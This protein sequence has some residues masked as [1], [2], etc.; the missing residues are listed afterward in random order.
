MALAVNVAAAHADTANLLTR[1]PLRFEANDGQTDP[2]VKFLA[3]GSAYTL[4]L[5]ADDMVLA[6]KADAIRLSFRGANRQARLV[7][8]DK[9]AGETNV[10]V[11]SDPSKWRSRIAGYAKIRYEE[12]YPGIDL[13]FYGNDRQLE[14]DLIVKPGADPRRIRM[15]VDGTRELSGD[16]NGDLV[17]RT[18]EGEIRFRRPFVYQAAGDQPARTIEGRYRVKGRSVSFD[19]GNYDKSKP[20][21]IDPIVV[22]QTYLGGNGDDNPGFGLGII[23]VDPYGASYVTGFTDSSTFPAT[24]G[25]YR[26]VPFTGHSPT[27][28]GRE[29][30][31][32]PGPFGPGHGS[33]VFVAKIAPDGSSLVYA[34]Y[35]GGTHSIFDHICGA[36]LDYVSGIAVDTSGQAYITGTSLSND[37]PETTAT[38]LPNGVD[39][40]PGNRMF[41]TK[42]NG[43]G[44]GLVFSARFGFMDSAGIAVGSDRSVYLTG[45]TDSGLPVTPGAFQQ[46]CGGIPLYGCIPSVTHNEWHDAFALKLNPT[47]TALVY[48]TYLGGQGLDLGRSIAVGADGQAYVT[49]LTRA[50]DFPTTPGAMPPHEPSGNLVNNLFVTKVNADGTDLIFS[51]YLGG[52]ESEQPGSV[53][54]D[55]AG[56]AYVTGST[57]SPDFPTT[58]GVLQETRPPTLGQSLFPFVTKFAPDGSLVYS[59]YLDYDGNGFGIAVD[60]E[61]RAWV[62]GASE[63]P[64]IHEVNPVQPPRCTNCQQAFIAAL[65]PT[66]SAF[67][68][69]SYIGGG[70]ALSLALNPDGDAF[71]VGPT[72]ANLPTVNPMQPNHAGGSELFLAKVA[73][74][75]VPVVTWSVPAP[76]A[77]GAPL[78]PAELDATA[79]IAGTFTYDPPAG[80]VLHAGNG[81]TLSVTFTPADSRWETVERSVLVDVGTAPLT[82]S[83]D[84]ANKFFGAPLPAVTASF[85]GFVNG[86]GPGNL[87]GTVTFSTSATSTSPVGPYPVMPGGVSSSDYAITFAP[88][89]LTILPA[90]T[91][92]AMA[93]V[94]SSAGFLQP[95]VVIAGVGALPPGA[96]SPDGTVQFL[97]GPTVVG[98]AVVTGGTAAV[99]LNGLASGVHSLTAVYSGSGNFTGSTSSGVSVTIRSAAA[100][101]FTL[102]ALANNPSALG[103]PAIISAIVVGLGGG[104]PTG[105]VQF[106]D[107][108]TP[109]ATIPL[110]NGI[111]TLSTASL[112]AGLHFVSARYLGNASFAASAASGSLLTVYTGLRPQS[113]SVTVEGTPSPSV[114]GQPVTFTATVRPVGAGA[115]GGLV[116]FLVDGYLAGGGTVANVGGAYKATASVPGLTAGAHV[117]TAIYTGDGAFASSNS[118]PLLQG[119][120]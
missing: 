78:G 58:G 52:S 66:A 112:G 64:L 103:Q 25:A 36:P 9:L 88:G 84:A 20:L 70:Y 4:F 80:T 24:P 26:Q 15:T 55:A 19:L 85:A 5:T 65:N 94:P 23:A 40:L 12:I 51:T 118:A 49:G 41:V 73:L 35:V 14:Y 71:V 83:A 44:S 6:R 61:G 11:G 101:T 93:A 119:V 7:P 16:G 68:L 82:V 45:Q 37:F 77:Y 90:A 53:A 86:D 42:L 27:E 104:T 79:S 47:G 34:T 56:F 33:N 89:T 120:Q 60:A 13:V 43:D 105:L 117:V 97:D 69:S 39:D 72:V 50:M 95:I 107:G 17:A 32:V 21:V 46:D 76:I 8:V 102:L 100:S 113:T 98:S 111:A 115:P 92:S 62:A 114:F 29:P 1:L 74:S 54:L 116:I 63:A 75:N 10:L 28:D 108:S 59:T 30:C 110:T 57:Q 18:T 2:R 96:G 31:T 91:A 109:L 106:L 87:T 48:A 81:Q 38:T 67:L 3:R 22:F 99:V